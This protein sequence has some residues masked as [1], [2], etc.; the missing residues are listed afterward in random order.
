M[1]V[2]S[3]G[4]LSIKPQSEDKWVPIGEVTPPYTLAGLDLAAE[5]INYWKHKEPLRSR[6]LPMA[7]NLKPVCGHKLDT[8]RLPKRN[9]DRCWKLFFITNQD[10]TRQ[11]MEVIRDGGEPEVV[12]KLGSKYIKQIKRFAIFVHDVMKAQEAN[13]KDKQDGSSN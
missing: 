13:E 3:E 4:A 7:N 8:T 9:C 6:L 5:N 12:K 10:M 1:N 11:N 2:V